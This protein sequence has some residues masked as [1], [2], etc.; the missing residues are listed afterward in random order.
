MGGNLSDESWLILALAPGL[1]AAALA[2][3]L[4]R[5]GDAAGI[6]AASRSGSLPAPIATAL[7]EP[8][9]IALDAAQTWL[10]GPDHHLL[11]LD[12]AR[13]P[14]LLREIPRPPVA[15]FVSGDPAALSLPQLAIVG[16]RSATPAGLETA[17]NFARH[18][19]SCG[20]CITSGLAAGIDAAAHRGALRA[21]GRTVAVCG[22]GPEQV[23]PRRHEELAAQ[24]CNSAGAVVTE[25]PPGTPIRRGNFPQRN[26]II[27][28]LAVGTL[29]VEASTSSGAL[30][31]ARHAIEQGREVFA[32]PGSIH[33]PVARGCHQLIRQGAKLVETSADI[34]EE[35]A[36]QL[37]GLRAA[38]TATEQAQVP[39]PA[40]ADADPEYQQLLAAMGW[41]EVNVDA[42]VERSGLTTGEV[43]SMLLILELH[44]SVRSLAG[45]RYQRVSRSPG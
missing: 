20:F 5:H 14:T 40:A 4:E 26:R 9:A 3:L 8:D 37:A 19:A 30:S 31:T 39:Q 24:I 38:I 2:T 29:V 13:Y 42:L 41:N 22:T 15:L 35:L 27:S 25:F 45:G 32:I 16:S 7:R 34:L 1:D 23:Y 43:S 12:D 6:I 17:E 18:L 11:G 28:G 10:A 33:N 36:G 21:G 44:G